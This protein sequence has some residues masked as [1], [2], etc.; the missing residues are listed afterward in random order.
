MKILQTVKKLDSLCIFALICSAHKANADDKTQ[1]NPNSTK[2]IQ[3][4]TIASHIPDDDLTPTPL[5]PKIW[6]DYTFVHDE[7]GIYQQMIDNWN[8]WERYD[9]EYKVW[10]LS[11]LNISRPD[12]TERKN[13][14]TKNL[15]KYADR[16]LSGE[17][18]HAE[19]GSTL[20]KVGSVQKALKPSTKVEFNKNYKLR[21]KA[22]LIEGNLKLNFIN[23]YIVSYAD[24]NRSGEYGIHLFKNFEKQKISYS[25]D[26]AVNQNSYVFN[27]DKEVFYNIDLFISSSQN[28]KTLLF[29]KESNATVGLRY[30]MGL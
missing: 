13:N 27:L 23:P 22:R 18:K 29:S 20:A 1:I 11:G 21:L 6:M 17:I 14:L 5:R 10:N 12:E 30:D 3:S 25:L 28:D 16:R 26:Y 2:K 4:R 9:H 24:L 8:N 19:K 7:A 15:I